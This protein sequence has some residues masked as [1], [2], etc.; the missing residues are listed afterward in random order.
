M[1]GDLEFIDLQIEQTERKIKQ[2]KHKINYLRAEFEYE[3]LYDI[4]VLK[5]LYAKRESLHYK[6]NKL[7]NIYA[8]Q[9]T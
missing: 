6:K 7:L 5:S 2:L 1:K 8:H 4:S 3:P 9:G